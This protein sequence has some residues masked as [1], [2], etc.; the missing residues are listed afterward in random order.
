MNNVNLN[1]IAIA[2]AM[3]II[4]FSESWAQEDNGCIMPK[5]SQ[6]PNEMPK[7]SETP[8]T[9]ATDSLRLPQLNSL[10]QPYLDAYPFGWMG[11][12]YGWN[13][14]NGLNVSM[15]MSVFASFGK[16]SHGGTGFAQR[17]SAMYA[18]PLS[19]KL[20]LAVGGYYGNFN[21]GSRSF[22]DA[23]VNFLCG[24]RFNEH[25]EGF[26]YGEKSLMDNPMP[27]FLR[28]MTSLGDK[29]GAAVKYNF[30]PSVSVT[31]SVEKRFQNGWD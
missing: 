12:C 24:Y 13:L 19:N 22:N 5:L 28:D 10:E 18:L 2:L 26:L 7:I 3:C 9:A 8:T 16:H 17:I 14:H 21:L 29:I 20:S 30:S 27:A 31:L 11:G 23:G 4:S 15:D 25:W 6:S 1:R